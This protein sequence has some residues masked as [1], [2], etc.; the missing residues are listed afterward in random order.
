M[1]LKEYFAGTTGGLLLLG[2]IVD[3]VVWYKA[4]NINFSDEPENT[5]G[6]TEEMANLKARDAHAA[7]NDYL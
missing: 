1:H 4:R 3:L 2:F 7:E 6:T 5:I